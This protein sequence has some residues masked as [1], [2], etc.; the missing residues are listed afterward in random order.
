MKT[1]G[2]SLQR[3]FSLTPQGTLFPA[4]LGTYCFLPFVSVVFVNIPLP[5]CLRAVLFFLL[6]HTAYVKGTEK[7]LNKYLK[8]KRSLNKFPENLGNS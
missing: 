4:L 8:S 1:P 3:K 6:C 2:P 5:A 7:V